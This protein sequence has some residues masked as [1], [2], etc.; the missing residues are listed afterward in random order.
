MLPNTIAHTYDHD[1]DGGTTAVIA[2]TLTRHAEE[3]NSSTYRTASHVEDAPD[4]VKF[5][6]TPAKKSGD[7]MGSQKVSVKRT[8]TQTVLSA[9]GLNVKAPFIGELS[10][11]VP[12]GV[13]N[14]EKLARYMEWVGFLSSNEGKAAMLSLLYVSEI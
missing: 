6:R 3:L 10:F 11:S 2:V 7:Y 13:T 8:K 9:A 14:A 4:T 1:N 12:V 5:Y